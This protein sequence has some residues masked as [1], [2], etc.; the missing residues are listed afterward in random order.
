MEDLLKIVLK[1]APQVSANIAFLAVFS[2]RVP[3][4]LLLLLLLP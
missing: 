1:L 4:L 3:H 2:V